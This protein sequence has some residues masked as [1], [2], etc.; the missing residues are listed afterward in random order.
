[1]WGN[2]TRVKAVTAWIWIAARDYDG[3]RRILMSI[4]ANNRAP[5]PGQI[6]YERLSP[7]SKE[8][9][10]QIALRLTA[11]WT[12]EEIANEFNRQPPPFRHV[13]LPKNTATGFTGQWVNARLW[14]LRDE[15]VE[16]IDPDG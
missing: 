8:V 6:R 5:L 15:M 1:V 12:S 7:A 14:T 16:S 3:H 4:L 9:L 11:G 13:P 10:G 2:T